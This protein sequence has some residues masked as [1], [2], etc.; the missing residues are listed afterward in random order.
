MKTLDTEKLIAAMRAAGHD[1]L[2]HYAGA[3]HQDIAAWHFCDQYIKNPGASEG[4]LR[5]RAAGAHADSLCAST[6]Q[7]PEW[8]VICTGE[9]YNVSDRVRRISVPGG[10]LYQVGDGAPVFVAG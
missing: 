7:S 9:R 5:I 10:W 4:E 2:I 3:A 6:T 1:H 8:N